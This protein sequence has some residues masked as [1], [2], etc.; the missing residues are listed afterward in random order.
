MQESRFT[1]AI[2]ACGAASRGVA[3]ALLLFVVACAEAPFD[4]PPPPPP[5]PSFDPPPGALS[6]ELYER[7][8][9]EARDPDGVP[10]RARW[11][12]SDTLFGEFERFLYQ[13]SLPG[14]LDVRA[15]LRFGS[16]DFVA[17]WTLDVSDINSTDTPPVTIVHM[18]PGEEPGTVVLLWEAPPASQIEV[19]L[20]QFHLYWSANPIPVDGLGAATE[21]L[22]PID[23]GLIVQSYTIRDLPELEPAYARIVVEDILD[24][25]SAV[26]AEVS[27]PSTGHYDL[28][29][30]IRYIRVLQDVAPMA[31][32]V[33]KL[34]L[35]RRVTD[36]SGEFSYLNQ[37]AF[38]ESPGFVPPPEPY[39][40]VSDPSG[41]EFYQLLSQHALPRVSQR[42]DLLMLPREL[43]PLQLGDPTAEPFEWLLPFLKLMTKNNRNA[44][45][46][47]VPH[48]EEY[49]VSVFAPEFIIQGAQ[50]LVDYRAA[51]AAA[52]DGWN[53]VA[54]EPLLT[55][56]DAAASP[57][58]G[59]TYSVDL[60]SGGNL[61]ETV[62]DEPAGGD[63]F[64]T[65]P[66][67]IRIRLRSFSSQSIAD[68]VVLH[69]MGHALGLWHSPSLDHIMEGGI[70][71]N[72]ADKVHRDEALLA[73]IIRHLPQRMDLKWYQEPTPA[74][75]LVYSGER[76]GPRQ[77]GTGLP[78]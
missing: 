34:D 13:P 52:V 77:C 50:E 5:E 54:G 65:I 46:L 51:F 61:G 78:D 28:T 42:L 15:E 6:V 57:G 16:R 67:Q 74:K 25:R 12:V 24:R 60:P 43:I 33:I 36:G 18:E 21:V 68:K 38:P 4:P 66:E 39:L 55:L 19:P 45:T 76:N 29:G 73:R 44:D 10:L 53:S 9:F 14:G 49:P 72:S 30:G 70:L 23:G 58:V 59:I 47:E 1:T 40:S 7:L 3:T 64:Q 2:S 56:A 26:S 27:A 37:P 48:W 20:R 17:N 63:L 71:T 31:N 62:M 22:R 35:E 41:A 32:A 11:F 69:E 75:P 8:R